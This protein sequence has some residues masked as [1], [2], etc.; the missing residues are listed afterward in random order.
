MMDKLPIEER[1]KDLIELI[2]RSL[3][4]I[5]TPAE[6]ARIKRRVF[7]SSFSHFLPKAVLVIS[8]VMLF[9]FSTYVFLGRQGSL[10]NQ[11]YH[12]FQEERVGRR[13]AVVK[14]SLE[15]SKMNPSAGFVL[16]TGIQGV[17]G[18]ETQAFLG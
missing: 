1:H 18:G 8:I 6:R 17:G 16:S 13:D 3:K 7:P 14:E 12:I 9:S 15:G 4:K 11:N 5:Q 10:N 2:V